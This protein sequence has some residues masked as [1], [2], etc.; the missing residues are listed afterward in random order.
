MV[1]G[2]GSIEEDAERL[3]VPIALLRKSEQYQDV[4]IYPDLLKSV[5]IFQDMLTQW[6]VG[7]SGA[8]GL[9]YAALPAVL[10]LRGILHD[11]Q[12]QIF[13]DIQI[14]ERAALRAMRDDA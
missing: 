1:G 9:D 12:S 6:R 11:E 5:G 7:M 8:T 2:G 14:M 3:G 13:D 10:G 4:E